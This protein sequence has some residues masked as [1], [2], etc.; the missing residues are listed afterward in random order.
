MLTMLFQI[1]ALAA[2]PSADSEVIAKYL[3]A[4]QALNAARRNSDV[5][6]TIQARLPKLNREATVRAVRTTSAMGE[7]RYE[8]R[9]A[10]GDAMVRREVIARYLAATSHA[11]ATDEISIAPSVYRFRLLRTIALSH[12][13]YVFRLT[14]KKKKAG[15]F[16]GELWVDGLT[17]KPVHESGQF[18]KNPSVFVKKIVF[19]RDYETESASGLPACIRST[20]ETRIAGPAELTIRISDIAEP[21]VRN[22]E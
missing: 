1:A 7:I 18:V 22:V 8:V 4:V 13:I 11:S 15:L 10:R 9:E 5:E 2:V 19:S 12:Q 3:S 17:G 21:E 6:V 16:K 20:V 14:P